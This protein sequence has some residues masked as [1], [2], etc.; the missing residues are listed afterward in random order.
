M[1]GS[2]RWGA[3]MGVRSAVSR[4]GALAIAGVALATTL[5]LIAVALV[6][7]ASAVQECAIDDEGCRRLV[8]VQVFAPFAAPSLVLIASVTRLS[9]R[10]RFSQL[11]ALGR[12]GVSRAARRWAVAVEAVISTLLGAATG[13]V[14]AASMVAGWSARPEFVLRGPELVSYPLIGLI[15]LVVGLLAAL[16]GTSRIGHEVRDSQTWVERRPSFWRVVPL[17]VGLLLLIVAAILEAVALPGSTGVRRTSWTFGAVIAA[18]GLPLATAWLVRAGGAL[19]TRI[20][21]GPAL[22]IAGR[23]LQAQSVAVTR[24]T[25]VL[26]T[27]VSLAVL[28]QGVWIVYS[29]SGTAAA[30]LRAETTGPNIALVDFPTEPSASTLAELRAQSWVRSVDPVALFDAANGAKVLVAS[31]DAYRSLSA[32]P[33]ARCVEGRVYS[34]SS[35]G[36]Q[37]AGHAVSVHA[38][39]SDD[40]FEVVVPPVDEHESVLPRREAPTNIGGIDLLVPPDRLPELVG[41]ARW[42][43]DLDPGNAHLIH[44][45]ELIP[46]AVAGTITGGGPE[47][48][49]WIRGLQTYLLGAAGAALVAAMAGLVLVGVDRA[50]ERRDLVAR[51]AQLGIPPRTMVRA[52]LVEQ[53]LPVLTLVPL[54]SALGTVLLFAEGSLPARAWELAA[55]T[56]ALASVTATALLVAVAL[57]VWPPNGYRPLRRE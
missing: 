27:T 40:V 26:V 25:A 31:C 48:L 10:T 41:Q 37:A 34:L 13:S 50:L 11:V 35:R 12:I 32:E 14:V 15:V 23:T 56:A 21:K 42:I 7:P 36:A 18:L 45:R 16:S 39:S 30:T 33:F 19:L 8:R 54:A 47:D 29:T 28:M 49:A 1:G 43:V 20:G 51:M 17:S 24:L 2:L 6:A 4:R 44:L 3:R 53:T 38:L 52:H 57:V 55:R 46:T 9:A 22:L 5:L